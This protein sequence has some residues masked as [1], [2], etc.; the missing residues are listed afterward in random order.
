MKNRI[1]RKKSICKN[2]KSSILGADIRN[3]DAPGAEINKLA[4]IAL[5]QS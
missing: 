2:G 5:G 3:I 1:V 4:V